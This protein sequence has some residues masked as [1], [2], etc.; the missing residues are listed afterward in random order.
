MKRSRVVLALAAAS[1]LLSACGY[2]EI[3]AQRDR[4]EAAWS[5]VHAQH[6]RRADLT[7]ALIGLVQAAA[8]PA[9]IDLNALD[10]A[11]A[12]VAQAAAA[13]PDVLADKAAFERYQQAQVDMSQALE[14]VLIQARDRPQLRQ[15]VMFQT[16]DAQLEG[17]VVRG[18][19]AQRD[20]NEAAAAYNRS[21]RAFPTAVWA[22]ITQGGA[23]PLPLLEPPA[24]APDQGR[25]DVEIGSQ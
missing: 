4:A 6:Q 16:L 9:P 18:A 2:G 11:R 5:D 10:Q 22:R 3:P 25:T 13:G 1:L 24:A 8:L 17:P 12:A 7:P 15:N 19:A 14:T 23:E 20:Y 21:L